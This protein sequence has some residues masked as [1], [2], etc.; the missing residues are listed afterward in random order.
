MADEEKDVEAPEPKK[1]SPII[2]I[3]VLVVVGLALAIPFETTA[4]GVVLR[5]RLLPLE[6]A[7]FRVS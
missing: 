4:D 3:A 1:K 7:V 6:P 2:L 5:V